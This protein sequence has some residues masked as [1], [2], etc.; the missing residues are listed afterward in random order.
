MSAEHEVGGT[1]A[2]TEEATALLSILFAERTG[3]A[4]RALRAYADARVDAALAALSRAAAGE[5]ETD[6][7]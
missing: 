5:K 2:T 4:I 3:D 1:D 6:H 7:A